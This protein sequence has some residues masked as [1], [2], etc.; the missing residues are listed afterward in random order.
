MAA[1]DTKAIRNA[2]RVVRE[3]FYEGSSIKKI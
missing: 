2:I 3:E 1:P